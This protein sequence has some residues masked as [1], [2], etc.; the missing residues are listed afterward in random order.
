MSED[1]LHKTSLTFFNFFFRFF[2]AFLIL[3]SIGAIAGRELECSYDTWSYS[4]W[5][6]FHYC[7]LSY[8]D[9]SRAYESQVHSFTGTA[10]QKSEATA[11]EFYIFPQNDFIPK[12]ILEEFPNLNGLI[13]YRCN[14]PVLKNDFFSEDFVVLEYLHLYEN[15]IVSIE[16]FAFQNLKNLKWLSLKLN[17][18]QSLPFN[19]FQSNPKLIYLDFD[20]NQINSISPNLLKNHNQLKWVKFGGNQ[21]VSGDFGC[22]WC[23]HTISQSDLDALLSTCFRNCLKDPECATK[24]ELVEETQTEKERDSIQTTP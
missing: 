19:L 9:L 15:Q 23:S 2:I 14:L 5:P 18:I 6:T 24:S 7:K 21:C 20:G 22:D 13:F 3:L 12:E 8:V 4:L 10:S 17:K 16:P 1:I 11:V